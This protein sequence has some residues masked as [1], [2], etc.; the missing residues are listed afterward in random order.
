MD[1]ITIAHGVKTNVAHI[2]MLFV[3][4][5]Q[6]L[7]VDFFKE[8]CYHNKYLFWLFKGNLRHPPSEIKD[9]K[10]QDINMTHNY[11]TLDL[12]EASVF[13]E[14]FAPIVC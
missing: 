10:F 2:H 5:M 13:Y 7:D 11:T 12:I 8:A 6:D 4:W 1:V 3:D 14:R 9:A